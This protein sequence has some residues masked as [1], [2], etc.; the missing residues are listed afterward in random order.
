MGMDWCTSGTRRTAA[1]ASSLGNMD[2]CTF[3]HLA[4]TQSLPHSQTPPRL[5]VSQCP[6]GQQALSPPSAQREGSVDCNLRQGDSSAS[7]VFAEQEKEP[8]IAPENT[9]IKAKHGGLLL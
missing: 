4:N 5:G 8:K 3:A 9:L 6:A 7:E 1:G 2:A